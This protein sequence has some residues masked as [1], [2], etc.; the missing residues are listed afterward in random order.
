MSEQY[1][2]FSLGKTSRMAKR[3]RRPWTPVPT[4]VTDSV[5]G[6]PKWRAYTPEAAPVR[7]AVTSPR[8]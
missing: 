7:Q 8:P 6:L 2:R 3:L 5:S 1:T 4:M